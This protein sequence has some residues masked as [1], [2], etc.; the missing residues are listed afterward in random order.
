MGVGS[1]ALL[2]SVVRKRCCNCQHASP[3]F[4]IIGR[5]HH[6]CQHPTITEE[7]MGWGSLRDW[8]STCEKWQAKTPISEMPNAQSEPPE[9][10]AR[11]SAQQ[12][13]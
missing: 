10:L 13:S 9:Y 11:L 3:G 4:R 12:K 7:E 1:T 8:Y 2:G 6:H 5:T